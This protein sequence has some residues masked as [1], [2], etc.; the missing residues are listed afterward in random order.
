MIKPVPHVEAMTPYA[1]AE[2]N[3]PVG[4][5]LVSLS[6]NESLIFPHRTSCA[7]MARWS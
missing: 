3:A 4:K 2:L 7:A 5:R 1:L 6:Q